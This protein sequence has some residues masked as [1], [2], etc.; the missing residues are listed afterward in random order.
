MKAL[1]A[2]LE[3][4][5]RFMKNLGCDVKRPKRKVVDELLGDFEGAIHEGETSA[6]YLKKLRESGYGK[7]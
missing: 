2:E 1:P 7:Y 5:L 6:E 4:I 3:E